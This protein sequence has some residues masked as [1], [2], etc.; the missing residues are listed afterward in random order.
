MGAQA[1]PVITPTSS[2]Q[3]ARSLRVFSFDP[4]TFCHLPHSRT[5]SPVW[6]S[7]I[8]FHSVNEILGKLC[9]MTEMRRAEL[10]DVGSG[11]GTVPVPVTIHW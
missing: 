9:V 4:F 7:Q 10:K 6:S 8:L 1:L 3:P 11:K 5:F 2:S